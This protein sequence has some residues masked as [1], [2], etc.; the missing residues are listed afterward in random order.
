MRRSWILAISGRGVR[1]MTF[2]QA[3]SALTSATRPGRV[4]I[5]PEPG[6]RSVST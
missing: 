2:S 5:R 3:V 6:V 1:Q 4:L